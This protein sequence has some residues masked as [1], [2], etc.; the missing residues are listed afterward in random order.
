MLKSSGNIVSLS[1]D[2]RNLLGTGKG[3]YL[4]CYCTPAGFY[5]PGSSNAKV[6]SL[7]GTDATGTSWG[8]LVLQ[9]TYP[10]TG[11]LFEQ[12]WFLRDGEAGLHSFSRVAYYNETTPFLRDLGEL[13]TLFR[14]TSNLWTH[15]STNRQH[16][17]PLP[18]A[19]ATG[20]QVVV[21]DATWYL[22]NTPND[23]YVQQEADYFTKY[24]FADTWRDHKAHGLYADGSTS[25]GTTYG[26]W[27]V[28]NTRDTYF[29]G[30]IHS[31]L[32]VDG[33]TYNYIVSNHHGDT[34]PNITHGFDRTFGP[35]FYYFNSGKNASLDA[36]RD[37]AEKYADPEWNAA[38]YDSIASSV[39]NYVTTSRRGTFSL[40]VSIPAE[41]ER[42]IA[43]LSVDG[44]DPQDNAQDTT[45]Y[46][47]WGDVSNSGSLTIPRVKEGTYRLTIYAD[48]IFG[49]YEEDGIVIAAGKDTKH[50]VKWIPES[51]G[52]ELWRIG[53]PDK[54][55]GEFRHGFA[56]DP[57]RPLHPQE[58]RIY[59]GQWDFP[60]DFPN[61]IN[62]TIGK[63]DAS[64][65]WN[66]VHWSVFGPSY[67]RA[68][69][70]STNMNNWTI[71]FE[72]AN[73]TGADSTG[74]LTIQLAGA[75]S[76]R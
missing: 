29:G 5:T 59:W 10:T 63:S 34:A 43:I 15:I 71:N 72:H 46:Q 19:E 50:E 57:S 62:Y 31:D 58:Y 69:A 1:L 65:D 51:A 75:K 49:Q 27:L 28:M 40:S 2:G 26:A 67:T 52:K 61:G 68:E 17:A 70:V 16:W 3:L 12:Y 47:Y 56:R 21:Q 11:Q 66:Y 44:L 4:D 55:A 37:D 32:T 14:P 33:I 30:P 48:G 6:K 54:T 60:T 18:S 76:S 22:G 42:T 36:L 45:A 8:G 20:K 73:A 38:F 64:K 23:T 35:F 41:A 53:T 13:R 7:N 25:N 24:T 74:T 9:D 39:P